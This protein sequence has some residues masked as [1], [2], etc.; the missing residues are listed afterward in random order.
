ML[1]QLNSFTKDEIVKPCAENFR[2]KNKLTSILNLDNFI[3]EVLKDIEH[4]SN[5]NI[6][7][8]Y[9]SYFIGS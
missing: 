7:I 3:A 4:A 8:E 6:V 2:I 1:T 5:S 9:D